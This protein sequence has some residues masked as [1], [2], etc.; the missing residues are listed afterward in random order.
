MCSDTQAQSYA[1][2][3]RF[4]CYMYQTI[5]YLLTYNNLVTIN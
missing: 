5:T 4:E 2:Y 3:Q 1:L